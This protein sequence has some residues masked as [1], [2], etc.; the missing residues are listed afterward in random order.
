MNKNKIK[1][2]NKFFDLIWFIYSFFYS[3]FKSVILF[4]SRKNDKIKS[5]FFDFVDFIFRQWPKNFWKKPN[6]YKLGRF[7][8]DLI[9]NLFYKIK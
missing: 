5:M 7:I 6:L 2:E 8:K 9:D 4:F 1:I 3:S